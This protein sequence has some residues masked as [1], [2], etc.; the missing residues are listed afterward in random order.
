[1]PSDPAQPALWNIPYSRNPFFT[2]RDQILTRLHTLLLANQPAVLVQPPAISGLGGIGKTQTAIE[3]AHRHR[4]EYRAIF[5]VQANSR[6]TLIA[7][8]T[9]IASLLHLPEQTA[10]EPEVT[11]QA[12]KYWLENNTSW[13]LI[14]DNADDL[15]IVSDLLPTKN[16]G[17]ILFTTRAT[18]MGNLAKRVEIDEMDMQEGALLLLR[19]AKI[20]TLDAPL[21]SAPSADL[22]VARTIAEA[23]DGLPLALDQ[24]GAYIEET[25]CSL[26]DYL[27]LYL[28]QPADLLQERGEHKDYH[29][30][31]VAKTWALSF[32]KVQQA[33]PAAADLLRFCAF[34]APDD[35]PEEVIIEASDDI[36]TELQSLV[37]DQHKLN[38]AIRELLK[39]SLIRRDGSKHT[40]LVHRLVQAVLRDEMN[41]ET[42][43]QWAERTIRA[44]NWSFPDVEKVEEWSKCQ[45][46]LPHALVCA[47]FIEK[48]EL[49]FNEAAC[50]LDQAGCYT[51]ERAQ[52]TEAGL[53]LEQ[54]LTIRKEILG[55]NH[56]DTAESLNNLG[57]FYW[58]LGK[59]TDPEPLYKQ[60]LAIYETIPEERH[61]SKAKT[62]NNLA[63]L[64]HHQGKY[65][66]A[67]PLYEQARVIQEEILG[68][69]HLATALSLNNL[70][71]LYHHQGKYAEAEPLY[72]QALDI[73][74][75]MLD[76]KHPDKAQSLN[77]L[78][79]LYQ[80]QGKY[81]EAELLYEQALDIRKEMLDE[82]HPDKAQSLNNLATLYQQQGKYAEAEPLYE[83]ALTIWKEVLGNKHLA[84]ALSLN[85]LATVYHYQEKYT[86]AESLYK[87]ILD[88]RKEILGNNHPDTAGSLNNLALLYCVQERYVEA[89]PLLKQ[90]L[91]IYKKVLGDSHPDTARSLNNV[92][93]LYYAQGKLTE[94]KTGAL[95]KRAL[96]IYEATLGPTHPD[97]I[98]VRDN[99]NYLLQKMKP[100]AP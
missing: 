14:F 83:Q 12:V 33:N 81:I 77:N 49:L 67:E 34:L 39:Y 43:K 17:H 71:L 44:V 58:E 47:R 87:R 37:G 22:T 28:E 16:S 36:G 93:L 9:K 78:A 68:K 91:G 66:E 30:D 64:Y 38:L 40:I 32:A 13:L 97:T 23:M 50:L 70:A 11:I 2:G 80:Q 63:I 20:L 74:K 54:A 7:D 82:K 88:I 56:P 27:Q 57:A 99:Y 5:W 98:T 89:E 10:R 92:V 48:W 76:E 3:Y 41:E 90:A 86:E 25:G 96:T 69:R 79:M 75:E 73:R 46:W 51:Y 26:P 6:E 42:Q 18:A 62:L 52:Y 100:I 15:S 19:R 29:P 55:E 94:T 31:P 4:E 65:A 1:M 60:A 8:S 59:D 72:E 95:L 45:Q 21:T 85:N 24:A 84:T 61:T 53:L 35:I